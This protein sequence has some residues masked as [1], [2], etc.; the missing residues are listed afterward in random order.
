MGLY[1][2]RFKVIEDRGTG[3]AL[4]I[5]DPAVTEEY[6]VVAE[7]IIDADRVREELVAA[8]LLEALDVGTASQ[9]VR[10]VVQGLAVYP[11]FAD[12][13]ELITGPVGAESATP[14][15]FQR[16]RATLAVATSMTGSQLVSAIEREAP[17]HLTIVR[18]GSTGADP[19]IAVRWTP[20]AP[21][22]E[23]PPVESGRAATGG[24]GK[25]R[26]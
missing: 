10:L 3:P 12:V 18:L 1:T 23:L 13:R 17:P 11:A 4:F 20:P 16:G 15:E 26:R 8:G 6:V 2:A 21:D 19:R 14:L 25:G 7:V 9:V 22:A 5:E 24:P